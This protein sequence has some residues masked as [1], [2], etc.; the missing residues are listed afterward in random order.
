MR[1]DTSL[2]TITGRE[3]DS[4]LSREDT[5]QVLREMAAVVRTIFAV[6]AG[7][8]AAPTVPVSGG[9]VGRPPG[10]PAAPKD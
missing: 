9:T 2:V 10:H 4:A 8:A 7:D 3:Q 1:A 5:A 6:E